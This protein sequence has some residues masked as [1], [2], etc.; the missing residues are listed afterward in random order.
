[1]V[2]DLVAKNQEF[3]DPVRRVNSHPANSVVEPVPGF[4][5]GTDGNTAAPATVPLSL[6]HTPEE[7][8]ELAKEN[9]QYFIKRTK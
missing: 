1:M 4:V 5:P 7:L 2:G 6:V 9:A 3:P 8:G